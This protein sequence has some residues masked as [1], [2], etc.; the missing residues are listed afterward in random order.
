MQMPMHSPFVET[1]DP[2]N[3]ASGTVFAQ[4]APYQHQPP[5]VAPTPTQAPVQ[6]PVYRTSPPAPLPGRRFHS[7]PPAEPVARTMARPTA[8]SATAN[9]ASA[10]PRPQL[11]TTIT[12]TLG[13][14]SESP[15]NPLGPKVGE[16]V[17]NDIAIIVNEIKLRS[18]DGAYGLPKRKDLMV[19]DLLIRTHFW[20]GTGVFRPES[21]LR[22]W[23]GDERL[24]SMGWWEYLASPKPRGG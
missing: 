5:Q 1:A 2:S 22:E 24:F 19:T 14:R 16:S 21:P 13:F 7:P 12:N 20:G 9:M 23:Y 15:A 17:P 4:Y 18:R 11:S 8:P 6:T 3:E 10:A